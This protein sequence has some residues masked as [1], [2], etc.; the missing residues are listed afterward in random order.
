MW[1]GNCKI[2]NTSAVACAYFIPLPLQSAGQAAEH[3][4]YYYVDLFCIVGWEKA[5][6]AII[7]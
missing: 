1:S 4:S 7:T 2:N 5:G 3:V 6:E